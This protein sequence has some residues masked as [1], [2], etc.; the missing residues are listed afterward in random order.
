MST[1]LAIQQEVVAK[2]A[3][4]ILSFT[5]LPVGWHYG[6]GE[7][8]SKETINLALRLN[9]EAVVA[10]FE[11]TNAFPSVEGEIQIT[12]WLGSLCL[13]FTIERDGG[14]TFAQEQAQQEIAYESALTLD[15]AVNRFRAAVD[16]RSIIRWGIY[17][18]S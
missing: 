16:Q 14:I 12:A 8:P 2:T 11:K 1:L 17:E 3:A 5:D 18:T 9:Q 13:E 15:E 6:D 7:P 4:K 10:G